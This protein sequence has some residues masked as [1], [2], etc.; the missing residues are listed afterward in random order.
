MLGEIRPSAMVRQILPDL[1]LAAHRRAAEKSGPG[2]D[3]AGRCAAPPSMAPKTW[4]V[5]SGPSGQPTRL[6]ELAYTIPWSDGRTL[7]TA[8]SACRRPACR[9]KKSCVRARICPSP[10]RCS[11]FGDEE[12]VRFPPA[13]R[14]TMRLPAVMTGLLTRRDA[15]G[16]SPAEGRCAS[17]AV[18]LERHCGPARDSCR[19]GQANLISISRRRAPFSERSGLP[20]VWSPQSQGGTLFSSAD[21]GVS[22]VT[23]TTRAST[24][25]ERCPCSCAVTPS[26]W[27][28]RWSVADREAGLPALRMASRRSVGYRRCRRGERGAG[29]VRSASMPAHPSER[30]LAGPRGRNRRDLRCIAS[31]RRADFA[32]TPFMQASRTAY[33]YRR[34]AAGP[35]RC[36][37]RSGSPHRAFPPVPS[38][39]CGDGEACGPGR[40]AV[41]ALLS[42]FF[43]LIL[44]QPR[45]KRSPTPI[46]AIAPPVTQRFGEMTRPISGPVAGRRGAGEGKPSRS[47]PSGLNAF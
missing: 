2:L 30:A 39:P 6:L 28:P 33:G 46:S 18:I 15:D 40:H 35:R 1:S 19:G 10:S 16:T 21:C 8:P 23:A 47:I 37:Q 11:L 7:R 26:P 36:A 45:R 5:A 13:C 25:G 31:R 24:Q 41:R 4:S 42:F 29:R 17:F 44:L 14:S 12:N 22:R 3:G 9:K 43:I 27:P 32:C 38:R 34:P 20:S